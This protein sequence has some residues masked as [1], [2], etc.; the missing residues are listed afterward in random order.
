MIKSRTTEELYRMPPQK[1]KKKTNTKQKQKTTTTHGTVDFSGHCS[2][3][4]LPFFHLAG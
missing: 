1:N 3:Q 2:D 4:Q